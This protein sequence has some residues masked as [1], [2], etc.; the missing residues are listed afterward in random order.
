MRCP[1]CRI[2]NDKVVDSRAS[3]DGL[4][5]R[6]RRLCLHCKRKYTTRERVDAV[7]VKVVKKN[8]VRE[9]FDSQK[10]RRGL[11]NACW[12]RPVSDE[13]IEAIV[14]AVETDIFANFESEVETEY[15]GE[16]VMAQLSQLDQ[17]A[18]VR[19]ASVYRSFQDAQDFVDEVEP[20]IA[21]QVRAR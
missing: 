16:L 8:G 11:A 2:D 18:Y 9:P 7:D 14:S 4:S 1:Y 6:R 17:V 20:I 3:D 21:R 19:F 13:Q 10:I 5:I 15:L 12:K